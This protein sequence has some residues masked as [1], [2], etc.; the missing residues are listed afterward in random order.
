MGK[1]PDTFSGKGLAIAGIVL[2]G[3]S[4]VMM[5]VLL[6]FTSLGS[7]EPPSW[8]DASGPYY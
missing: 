6:I 4:I 2:G 7:V 8:N 3:L 1:Q 5:I